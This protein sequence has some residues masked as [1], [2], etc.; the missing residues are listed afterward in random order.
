MATIRHAYSE[1]YI[2]P[3]KDYGPSKTKQSFKKESDINH[4]MAKYQKTGLV[5]HINEHQAQYGVATGIDFRTALEL[6]REAQGMFDAL[7]S[8]IRQK[9]DNDPSRFLT[10]VE[11]PDNRDEMALMGLLKE[12]HVPVSA[13]E[14]VA[15][16]A[17]TEPTATTPPVPPGPPTP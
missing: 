17:P 9:F 8:K 1:R 13:S 3:S 2:I 14:P 16:S 6:V 4:I 11:N 15:I 7:P 12:P 5:T 10:F